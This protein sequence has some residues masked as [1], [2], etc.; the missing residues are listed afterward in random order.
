MPRGL[1]GLLGG[2]ARDVLLERPRWEALLLLLEV[3][4]HCRYPALRR[5]D[6]KI[7]GQ[8]L[9]HLEDRPLRPRIRGLEGLVVPPQL[10][11]G[12]D[13]FGAV[14]GDDA[15]DDG[16]GEALAH[17]HPQGEA[18]DACLLQQARRR[19]RR[20]GSRLRRRP[21]A[22]EGAP[23]RHG[24][25]VR[26]G[27][28]ER[29]DLAHQ[30]FCGRGVGVDDDVGR[31]REPTRLQLAGLP[32][33]D[34]EAVPRTFPTRQIDDCRAAHLALPYGAAAEAA[35]EERAGGGEGRV[36][37]A[38]APWRR[39]HQPQPVVRDGAVSQLP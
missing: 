36:R 38:G 12:A 29:V 17:R 25:P 30:R 18:S 21:V 34:D 22:R 14:G 37:R 2:P 24:A 16:H 6:P 13:E 31:P 32:I 3:I 10:V 26:P 35:A 8:I 27:G 1:Q 7:L 11:G 4:A 20:D 23:A 5:N 15:E 39:Q 28:A 19:R 33:L 9:A